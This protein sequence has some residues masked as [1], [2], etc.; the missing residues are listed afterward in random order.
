MDCKLRDVYVCVPINVWKY[1]FL[2]TPVLE[3]PVKSTRVVLLLT[4]SGRIF[5][6]TTKHYRLTSMTIQSWSWSY[7]LA[8][9]SHRISADQRPFDDHNYDHI[10]GIT[11]EHKDRDFTWVWC[12]FSC[13][14]GSINTK[15][16]FF[17]PISN[18][19]AIQ[20]AKKCI[21]NT[22]K[23]GIKI[24]TQDK[25]LQRKLIH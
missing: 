25:K 21:T 5:G 20:S 19:W 15:S 8:V 10:N 3:S 2:S 14:T 23:R 22:M 17:P 24:K 6:F 4:L 9:Y 7:V 18:K 11:K 1:H 16:V 12:W 13:V